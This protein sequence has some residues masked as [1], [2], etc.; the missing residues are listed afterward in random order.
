MVGRNMQLWAAE[1]SV[2]PFAVLGGA[3]VWFLVPIVRLLIVVVGYISQPDTEK[4]I[5]FN[6]AVTSREFLYH[7]IY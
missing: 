5:N 6:R 3:I 1:L 2:F 4:P 7:L